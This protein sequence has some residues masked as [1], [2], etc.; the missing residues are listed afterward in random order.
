M[1]ADVVVAGRAC[2]TAVFAAVPACLGLPIGP[3]MH[4]AKIIECTSLCCVPGGRD[5]IIATLEGEAFVLE[6]MNPDRHATPLSVAAHALYE[7]SDP[8][9]VAEPEGTLHLERATYA[10]LDRHR[11]RVAG[12]LWVPARRLRIKVEGALHLGERAVLFAASAD[13]GFISAID[14]ILIA[15]ERTTRSLFPEDFRLFPRVYGGGA[16]SAL[17]P[18]PAGAQSIGEAAVLVECVAGT[19]EIA[20]G[21]LTVFRQHL[22]HHGFQGRLSTGGNLAFPLTPPE[23]DAGPAYRFSLYHLM[24]VDALAPLFPVELETV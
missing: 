5:T 21:A 8:F 19:R 7:Q 6:S 11:T 2:D 18:G 15:V 1:G 12:A 10:A 4:M 9:R 17:R 13:P 23:F 14:E 20:R 22:L 3:A 24:D 16:G